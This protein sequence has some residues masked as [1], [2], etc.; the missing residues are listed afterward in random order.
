MSPPLPT[1]PRTVLPLTVALLLASCVLV[2]IAILTAAPSAR[3]DV[4]GPSQIVS[5]GR[6]EGFEVEQQAKEAKDTAISGNG[7]YVVFDGAFG[8][9]T[10]VF[11]R[12]LATGEVQVVAEGKAELPSIS[13]TGQYVSFTTNERLDEENDRNSS[14]D[15]YVRNMDIPDEGHCHV[16][17]EQNGEQCPFTIASAVDGSSQG[18]EYHY[19]LEEGEFSARSLGFEESHYG[20]LAE[21]RSALDA[22]GNEVVFVTIASSDLN[23]PE[24]AYAPKL[25]VVVR[26]L[27][28]KRTELVSTVYREGQETSEPV[29]VEKEAFRGAAFPGGDSPPEFPHQGQLRRRVP[30]RRRERRRLDGQRGRQT[31]ADARPREPGRRIRRSSVARNRG[32]RGRVHETR[33]GRIGPAESGV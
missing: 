22:S 26:Y 31:G 4:F 8:G 23:G 19:E 24:K 20:S 18:L 2:A 12:D 17:W 28:T 29:P 6:L 9:K 21:G 25:Q 10:G 30:E 1:V 15:V 27:E 16:E 32:I 7:Q 14:P 33:D 5:V 11:R 13:E 3:A